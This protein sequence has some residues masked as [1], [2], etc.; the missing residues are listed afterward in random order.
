VERE[1]GKDSFAL[2][3]PKTISFSCRVV[4]GVI[5]AGCIAWYSLVKRNKKKKNNGLGASIVFVKASLNYDFSSHYFVIFCC[6]VL[7]DN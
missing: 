4:T 6:I 1:G 3:R 5:S 7:F 2:K